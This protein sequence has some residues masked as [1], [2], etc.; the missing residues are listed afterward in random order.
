MGVGTKWQAEHE[1]KRDQ[2]TLGAADVIFCQQK[3][4]DKYYRRNKTFWELGGLKPPFSTWGGI[5][6]QV[7]QWSVTMVAIWRVM[8]TVNLNDY[9]INIIGK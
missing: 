8:S 2:K 7:W 9:V 3:L 4:Y 1:N 5:L 6:R